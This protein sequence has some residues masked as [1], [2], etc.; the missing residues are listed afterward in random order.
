MARKP[1]ISIAI[2]TLMTRN[3][4]HAW[5][6]E[7]IHAD[8]ARTGIAT[9]FSSVFRAAEKLVAEGGIRKL[10]VED[11]RTYFERVSAHHDHLHCTRCGELVAIPCIVPRRTL[12]ALEGKTGVTI[13]AHQVSFVGLCAN[14]G[15]AS[16]G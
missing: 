6:L 10:Q 14:C 3:E 11:G 7:D 13:T 9:D 8:L 12:A 5:T 4:R 2:A 1:R 15:A 16:K